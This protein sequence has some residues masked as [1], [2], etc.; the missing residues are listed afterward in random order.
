M[1]GDKEYRPNERNLRPH[2]QLEIKKNTTLLIFTADIQASPIRIELKKGIRATLVDQSPSICA[3]TE[4]LATG[5]SVRIDPNQKIEIE[6]RF[7]NKVLTVP[8]QCLKVH[9]DEL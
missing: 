5:P 6:D 9:S 4:R 7:L 3:T 8:A 1:P 2:L